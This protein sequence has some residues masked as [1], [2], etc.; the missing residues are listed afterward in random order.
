MDNTIGAFL[1]PTP[2]GV[3]HAVAAREP[4]PRRSAL[5]GLLR[6]AASRP[7]P[8]ALLGELTGL[9]DRKALGALLYRMQREGWVQ[10][11]MEPL[12]LPPAPLDTAVAQLLAELSSEGTVV[13]SDSLGLCFACAGLARAD[14]DDLAALGAGV[15]PLARRCRIGLAKDSASAPA[16]GLLKPEGG[17]CFTLRPLHI[18][19]HL[20]HLIV[21]GAV[22]LRSQSF[23]RLVALLSRRYLGAC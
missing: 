5:S 6:G 18:G 8:L 3:D 9:S 19:R 12:T 22:N 23:V 17:I 11:E 2:A 21:G 20:F 4:D 13:L 10:G 7:M 1:V 14:A 16:W 15:Y